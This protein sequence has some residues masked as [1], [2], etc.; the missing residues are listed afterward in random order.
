MIGLKTKHA[1]CRITFKNIL[2]WESFLIAPFPDLCLLVPFFF[3]SYNLYV[4]NVFC[5]SHS[6]EYCV[7]T[8]KRSATLILVIESI[9][10]L[11]VM[12]NLSNER[13]R[14]NRNPHLRSMSNT[15]PWIET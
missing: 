6:W 14:Y 15:S 3:S 8:A 1:D 2:E 12:Q 10:H 7:D 5:D 13:K 9:M 11:I 4:C